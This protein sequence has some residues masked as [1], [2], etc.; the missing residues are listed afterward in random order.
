LAYT[1]RKGDIR[2]PG[3]FVSQGGDKDEREIPVPNYFAANLE[4]SSD[5][6]HLIFPGWDPERRFG[7]FRVSLED[8][9]IE[10][11]QLG[12]T[13]GQGF[14]G[15]FINLRWLAQAKMFSLDKMGEKNKIR[16][17]YQMDEN[18]R[19]FQLV[20]DKILADRWTW[21][22]PSGKYLIY[23]ENMQD[24]KLWSLEENA[25]ITTITRFP[26]GKTLEWPAWSPDGFQ[27]AFKDNKQLKVL[28]LPEKTSRVLVEIGEN[29]EI[30]VPWDC[31]LAWSPD[32]QTIAYIL[33]NNSIGSEPHYELWTV[34]ASG[35]TPRKIADAP[36]S[37]PVLG[38]ISWHPSGKLI[39]VQG[40]TAEAESRTF[41]HW[42]LEN[43]LPKE[44][45]SKK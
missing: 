34:T 2:F 28:S 29:S 10:P 27:V 1:S 3:I 31:G 13:Y 36:A 43:F 32:G 41:E 15:A 11:L 7:I 12:D 4:W 35:G 37:H 19:N 14:K 20:T 40:K 44:K 18:G 21:P 9:R 42:A 39:T 38:G 33:Q 8:F 24:L 25:H 17:I 30:G 16:E 22:S 5:G 23:L 6:Q 45:S 26:E